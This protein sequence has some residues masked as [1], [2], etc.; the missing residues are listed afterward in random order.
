MK[1]I[2]RS[3]KT[4]ITLAGPA[5]FEVQTGRDLQF[6]IPLFQESQSTG[7][8]IAL[9]D[10]TVSSVLATARV[11][12]FGSDYIFGWV[13][14]ANV[15][16]LYKEFLW[17]I[18][19]TDLDGLEWSDWQTAQTIFVDFTATSIENDVTYTRALEDADGNFVFKMR[20]TRSL[21]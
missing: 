18:A 13:M 11:H 12:P 4:Q 19:A 20:V 14:T 10:W 21:S 9:N 7:Q 2:R 5:T 16:S 1:S 17:D 6:I 8:V 15:V 3:R